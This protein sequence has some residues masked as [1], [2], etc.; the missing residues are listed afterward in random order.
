MSSKGK[1]NVNKEKSF[2]RLFTRI[3]LQVLEV[4]I[5][6][7]VPTITIFRLGNMDLDGMPAAAAGGLAL[8]T[9]LTSLLF[10]RARAYKD[11][12]V[13]RRSLLAAELGLRA[14]I[15]AAGGV[16]VAA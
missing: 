15:F 4:G 6:S 1:D 8:L 7:V 11:G 2:S 5:V 14:L 10:N 12:R 13:Q 3:F 16:C 9:A